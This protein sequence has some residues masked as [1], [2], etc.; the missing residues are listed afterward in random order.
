MDTVKLISTIIMWICIGIYIYLIWSNLYQRERL[1]D[2]IEELQ[3]A[4]K[5]CDAT[6]AKLNKALDELQKNGVTAALAV[7]E[8]EEAAE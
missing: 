2:S 7:M 4:K 3:E 8:E 6:T 1:A 5:R